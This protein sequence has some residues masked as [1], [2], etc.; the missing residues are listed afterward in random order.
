MSPSDPQVIH[1]LMYSH[2]YGGNSVP[3]P[4]RGVSSPSPRPPGVVGHAQPLPEAAA[5]QDRCPVQHRAAEE[6][7][8]SAPGLHSTPGTGPGAAVGQEQS[9]SLSSLAHTG[10]L[11]RAP[12]ARVCARLVPGWGGCCSSPRQPQRATQRLPAA[13][14]HGPAHPS[15]ASSRDQSLPSRE[16]TLP[17]PSPPGA[18]APRPRASARAGGGAWH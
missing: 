15:Q 12:Q 3:R 10:V 5:G 7:G 4:G 2:I 18:G 11:S 13:P 6:P 8:P 14:G 9:L 16:R 17:P 1:F